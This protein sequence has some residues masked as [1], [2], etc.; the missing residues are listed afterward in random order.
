MDSALILV[1]QAFAQTALACVLLG[2][3]IAR[4][5]LPPEGD[6]SLVLSVSW[7]QEDYDNDDSHQHSIRPAG[8]SPVNIEM[9]ET[10]F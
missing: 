3:C 9:N 6:E 10:Y 1:L 5:D 7:P 4:F 8:D 2:L